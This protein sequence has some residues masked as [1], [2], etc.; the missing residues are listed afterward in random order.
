VSVVGIDSMMVVYAG[1]V[2]KGPKN[3]ASTPEYRDLQRRAK[4]LLHDLRD[5]MVALPMVAVGEL[6]IPVPASKRGLLI[7]ALREI[8]VCP[9]YDDKAAAIAA[10]LW[11]LHK[12]LPA[13]LKYEDRQVL[14]SDCMIIA[15]AKAI[16][17][18]KFYTHDDKCR[19][20]ADQVMFGRDLPRSSP[21]LF[22]EEALASGETELPKPR[23]KAARKKK[24]K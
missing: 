13:D 16:G 11:S 5:Q 3:A 23:K 15:S 17:A 21:D 9:D 12:N 10:D 8:F 24:G 22:I 14:R 7:A 1:L 18:T 2:P 19:T 6:L 20:L 4:I